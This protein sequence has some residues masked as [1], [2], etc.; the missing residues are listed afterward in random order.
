MQKETR[1]ISDYTVLHAFPI[2]KT[3]IIIADNPDAACGE[4]FLLTNA[5]FDGLFERYE[6]SVVSDNYLEIVENFSE[7]IKAKVKELSAEISKLDFDLTP[8]TLR[9]CK[10]ISYDEPIKDMVVVIKQDVFKPEH[11][12]IIHQLQL[13]TGG[14]GS[15]AKSRGSAC[16]C[17]NLY[18]GKEARYERQDVLGVIEKENLPEWAKK[19]LKNAEK[20]L[21]EKNKNGRSA[22]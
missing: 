19:G 1:K 21:T 5:S 15:Y 6:K 2:G 18:T 12:N 13:C 20:Q 14:F 3:E 11:Q 7:R 9:D 22:R 17:T 8:L 4:R 16:F 10:H